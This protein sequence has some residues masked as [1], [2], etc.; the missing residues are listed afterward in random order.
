[1]SSHQPITSEMTIEQRAIARAAN[2]ARFA[3]NLRAFA[4]RQEARAPGRMDHITGDVLKAAEVCETISAAYAAGDKET[5]AA[6]REA[7]G[8][9]GMNATV[10]GAM[11][12]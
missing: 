2:Y 12:G 9:L 8:L 6:N 11:E 4:D 7:F 10:S 5:V 3:A 1:M